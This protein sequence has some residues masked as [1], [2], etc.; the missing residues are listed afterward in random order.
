MNRIT[1]F[2]AIL[3]LLLGQPSGKMADTVWAI[4]MDALARFD[5]VLE[6]IEYSAPI[7]LTDDSLVAKRVRGEQTLDS[8]QLRRLK[9]AGNARFESGYRYN[10]ESDLS[11]SQAM[12]HGH[13]AY[14]G[15]RW[16]LLKNGLGETRSKVREQALRNQMDSLG[17]AH[18]RAP[19]YSAS[20]LGIINRFNHARFALIREY[21]LFLERT[22]ALAKNHYFARRISSAG[23][24]GLER[25]LLRVRRK[26][27]TCSTL[28]ALYG[29]SHPN[30][31][32]LPLPGIGPID[33]PS[34]F[35]ACSAGNPIGLRADSLRSL[36][37]KEAAATSRSFAL[38]AYVRG[39]VYYDDEMTHG[40]SAGVSF[41]APLGGH[42]HERAYLR[43]RTRT[44]KEAF[45]RKHGF[46]RE[47]LLHA[48][49][50]VSHARNRYTDA[51]F[52]RDRNRSRFGRQRTASQGYQ[53]SV[54]PFEVYDRLRDI[55]DAEMEVLDAAESTA[56]RLLKLAHAAG[57]KDLTPFM[58]FEPQTVGPVIRKGKR[59]V[60]VWSNVLRAH[61]PKYLADFLKVKE[62]SGVNVAMS[63][64]LPRGSLRAFV[65]ECRKRGIT[66]R[67]M[68]HRLSLLEPD[69]R[70]ALS[71]AVAEAAEITPDGL[72]LD[73]E[74]HQHK[75]WREND[76]R[77]LR[78]FTA[79]LKFVREKYRGTIDV[80]I[81]VMY[82]TPFLEAM[83]AHVDHVTVMAYGIKEA[84]VFDNRCMEEMK[85]F[86]GRMTAGVR[87][88]D[89]SSEG[90]MEAYIDSLRTRLGLT[91]FALH[92]CDSYITMAKKP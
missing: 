46:D 92:D 14:A 15:L 91:S 72:H 49:R 40:P 83:A 55:F 70:E 74:P 34:L 41:S 86:K 19:S 4:S 52:R 2:P 35:E 23:V 60:Y 53:V 80:S 20:S 8:L 16:K 42:R 17:R 48:Y 63:K 76:F 71:A 61:S 65:G 62:V 87:C 58:E 88:G 27:Q 89:F 38:D 64:R 22:A 33:M 68:L 84:E 79:M 3:L 57:L 66:V 36:A 7:V 12:D 10:G 21:R 9:K 47:K 18:G 6:R 28:V 81:P 43:H 31:A 30:S 75:G 13:R 1:S 51:I 25:D 37:E 32:P 77:R 78:D 44:E 67:I 54:E 90:M 45:D 82:P 73:I 39:N 26:A 56:L 59:W 5:T 11:E 85:L 50:E 29:I 24:L 69:K